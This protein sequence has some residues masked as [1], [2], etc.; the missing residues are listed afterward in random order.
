MIQV[1]KGDIV[2]YAGVAY[3]TTFAGDRILHLKSLRDKNL[4]IKCPRDSQFLDLNVNGAEL[5]INNKS[6][7][8]KESI[9]PAFKPEI[10]TSLVAQQGVLS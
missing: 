7:V 4:L 8:Q 3:E 6:Y 2:L 10:N 5:Q 1:Q 9:T